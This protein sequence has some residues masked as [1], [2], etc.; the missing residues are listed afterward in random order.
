MSEAPLVP[1]RKVGEQSNICIV[2]STASS[3]VVERAGAHSSSLR[4]AAAARHLA[5]GVAARDL[6]VFGALAS[7]KSRAREVEMRTLV[8]YYPSSIWLR[9]IA[10]WE[11]EPPRKR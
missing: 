4:C 8:A 10:L 2:A 7:V 1:L 5:T 11:Q 3:R 9:P 6:R